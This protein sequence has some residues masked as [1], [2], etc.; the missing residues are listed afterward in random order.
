MSRH[1]PRNQRRL[2]AE[3]AARWMSE[4]ALDDP[5]VALRGCWRG[6]P[7][8]R[9]AA[10]GRIRPKSSTPCAS[11]SAC[12]VARSSRRNWNNGAAAA[13]RC[14]LLRIPPQAGGRRAGRHRRCQLAGATAP[15]GDDGEAL[16]LF[17]QEQGIAHRVVS[18]ASIWIH[19]SR[20]GCRM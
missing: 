20:C 16:L 12:S 10:S 19:A 11:T 17:L 4:H 8:H 7:R 3:Q 14:L 2:L 1:N 6:C 9:T 18:T 15:H 5:A 13:G